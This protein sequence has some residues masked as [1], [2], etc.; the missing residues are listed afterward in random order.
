MGDFAPAPGGGVAQGGLDI[1]RF[2]TRGLNGRDG[3]EAWRS[4][5][6]PS[7]APVLDSTPEPGFDAESESLPLGPFAVIYGRY[8]A[9]AVART[10][11]RQR[12]APA[13][14]LHV[15]LM[16]SG[17]I[18]G[19]WVSL[20]PGEIGICSLE[21]D[22]RHR[23]SAAALVTFAIPRTVAL[24]AGLDPRAFHGIR[25]DAARAALLRSHL[26]QVRASAAAIAPA[27]APRLAGTITD[28]LA[29]TLADRGV[30]PRQQ[31]V[32]L[33]MRTRAEQLVAGAIEHPGLDVGWLCRR[34]GVSRATLYR[35]FAADGGVQRH[36]VEA[37]LAAARDALTVSGA[38][39]G[40]LAHRFGF[41]DAAHFS[42][43]FRKRYG[44][45]PRDCR[46]LGFASTQR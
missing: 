36:I 22:W 4:Q 14:S 10:R 1:V 8:G 24:K 21:A 40:D 9:Q 12:I 37:R 33:A 7:L 15:C 31:A 18:D 25:I 27:D 3:H 11:E 44:V 41:S 28:L 6:W 5:G 34:L 43:A 16:L 30:A 17:R 42:R 35:L 29:V 13:D 32:A 19:D 2:S 45:S 23:S 38:R 26:L 20:R 39:I 46:A